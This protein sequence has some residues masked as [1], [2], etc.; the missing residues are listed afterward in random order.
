MFIK[1]LFNNRLRTPILV[2]PKRIFGFI[3]DIEVGQAEF[4]TKIFFLIKG[5]LP[6][7]N[8]ISLR[9]ISPFVSE[10]KYSNF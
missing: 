7:L 10:S 3:L 6:D 4:S 1:R 8:F 2:C 5:V 9:Y